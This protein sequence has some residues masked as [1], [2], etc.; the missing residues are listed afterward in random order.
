MAVRQAL[1]ADAARIAEIHI[2][3][4]QTAFRRIMPENL[5]D[6]QNL[7]ERRA[8][9]LTNMREYP[10]NLV[11]V[12]ECGAGVLGFACGGPLS[13][14]EPDRFNGQVFGI[15]VAPD[16]KRRGYGHQL[17][18]ASR[19]DLRRRPVALQFLYR[20]YFRRFEWRT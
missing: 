5:L 15:H 12:E 1:S 17:M 7:E 20:I 9:W 8:E 18:A 13:K 16:V 6:H 19:R 2:A 14:L 11:V 10:G 4:W 3:S